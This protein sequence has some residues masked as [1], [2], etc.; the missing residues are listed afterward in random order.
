MSGD[1][2]QPRGVG[3]SPRWVRKVRSGGRWDERQ[4]IARGHG[5]ESDYLGDAE[6][7]AIAAQGKK[8]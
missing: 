3:K 6:T 4:R 8:T 5:G 1:H 7:A 2:T